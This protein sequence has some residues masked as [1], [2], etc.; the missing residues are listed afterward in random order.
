MDRYLTLSFRWCLLHCWLEEAIAT[1]TAIASVTI[2]IV[3]ITTTAAATIAVIEVGWSR[4]QHTFIDRKWMLL[5]L[6]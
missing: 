3:I 1:A 6:H 2:T 5:R 4:V